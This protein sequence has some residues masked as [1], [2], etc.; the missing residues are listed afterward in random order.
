M[1]PEILLNLVLFIPRVGA[2]ALACLPRDSHSLVRNTAFWIAFATLLLSL[3]LRTS[4]NIKPTVELPLQHYRYIH[5][6]D[7][8]ILFGDTII[9]FSTLC[10]K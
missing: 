8:V 10:G 5:I 9:Q 4:F 3:G 7:R 6:R 1:S 2:I